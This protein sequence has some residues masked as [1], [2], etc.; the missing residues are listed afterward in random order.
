MVSAERIDNSKGHTCDN[1]LLACRKC[2][3][4]R[5]D[6]YTFL[7]YLKLKQD[8]SSDESK[9]TESINE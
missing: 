7:E 4:T 8:E 2:N 3:I 5:G 1:V 6:N 9:S